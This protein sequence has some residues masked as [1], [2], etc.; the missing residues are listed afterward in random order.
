[1]VGAVVGGLLIFAGVVF[2]IR[3]SKRRNPVLKGPDQAAHQSAYM[4][5][6]TGY[7]AEL[8][9]GVGFK[10]D[11]MVRAELDARGVAELDAREE[12]ELDTGNH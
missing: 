10:L 5:T 11:S 3:R 6:F 1:M 12:A 8:D 4:H 9:A 7:K 2:L